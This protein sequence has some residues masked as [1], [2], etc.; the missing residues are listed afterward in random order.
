M[1]IVF[2][3]SFVVSANQPL[4]S[5]LRATP[6]LNFSATA[7]SANVQKVESYKLLQVISGVSPNWYFSKLC[8]ALFYIKLT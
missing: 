2:R 4:K 6:Q 5:L 3:E 8:H 1:N 7:E